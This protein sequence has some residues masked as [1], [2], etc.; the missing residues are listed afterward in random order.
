MTTKDRFNTLPI[1]TWLKAISPSAGRL[2]LLHLS[3]SYDVV[4]VCFFSQHGDLLSV[5]GELKTSEL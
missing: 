2:K 1:S 5:A 3:L 4:H